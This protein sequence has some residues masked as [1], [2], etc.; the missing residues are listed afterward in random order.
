MDK[1]DQTLW[2][3]MWEDV[4]LDAL[5]IQSQ[6]L[7]DLFI[8]EVEACCD[9]CG[10]SLA[11]PIPASERGSHVSFH[12]EEGF[13]IMQALIAEGGIGDFRTPDIIRFGFAPLYVTRDDVIDAV[14]VLQKIM[15]TVYGMPRN[16]E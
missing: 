3:I 12:H 13:A 8:N 4:N 6:M 5:R 10:L 1:D 9:G 2:F 15:G 7:T 14:A 11:S 16:L